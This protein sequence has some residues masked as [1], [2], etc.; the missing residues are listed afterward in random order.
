[1]LFVGLLLCWMLFPFLQI[2][3]LAEDAVP[4]IAAGRVDATDA[5]D[6]YSSDQAREVPTPL[7]D[8]GC[9]LVPP[10][11]DCDRYVFPFLAPPQVL[12]VMFPISAL[13]D[14]GSI[15]FMRLL[16]A[17]SFAGGFWL[18]W[19]SITPKN[20][21]AELP[22]FVTAVILTPYLYTSTAFGQNAPLMFLSAC[23]GLS[24]SERSRRGAAAAAVW[25]VTSVFKLFPLPL[26]AVALYRRKWGFL[27]WS[28]IFFVALTLLAIPLSAPNMYTEF[29]SSS[30]ALTTNRVASQWNMSVDSLIQQFDPAWRGT[31][32]AFYGALLAR[33][34]VVGGLFWWKLR[35]A[36]EDVQWSYAWLALLVLHPQ[37][38]WYYFGLLI[39]AL[40]FAL[41]GRRGNWWWLLVGAAVAVLALAL[42]TDTTTLTVAGP[43]VAAAGVIAIPFLVE[44]S[45]PRAVAP[46]P[47]PTST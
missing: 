2:G 23:L 22:L 36:D 41:R 30:Q 3:T 12:P 9:P 40:A 18:L 11:T 5:S 14:V 27:G 26:A 39:P 38:W 29:L 1:M 31:G 46:A 10:G 33:L 24:G 17:A 19:R 21:E 6:L 43:I 20:P 45:R 32:A 7:R 15:L 37:I 13:G 8:A 25:V 44:P 47:A 28:A 42:V 34:V 16:G 35:D 4:F